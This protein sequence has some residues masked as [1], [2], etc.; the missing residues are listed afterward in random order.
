[1]NTLQSYLGPTYSEA[2]SNLMTI[3]EQRLGDKYK[4]PKYLDPRVMPYDI[5][6]L[7]LDQ[8]KKDIT[9]RDPRVEIYN[10]TNTFGGLVNERINLK[11]IFNQNTL[12]KP[13]LKIIG[14]FSKG[15]CCCKSIDKF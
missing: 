10:K 13:A 2:M 1:M 14:L 5:D 12:M 3:M 7:Q 4:T 6:L 11:S 8:D 9:V 15:C